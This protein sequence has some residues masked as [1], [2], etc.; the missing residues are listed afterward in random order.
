LNFGVRK[1]D[2]IRYRRQLCDVAWIAI[3]GRRRLGS[4]FLGAQYHTCDLG[5][6]GWPA[7][8]GRRRRVDIAGLNSTSAPPKWKV[9]VLAG[10][11]ITLVSAYRWALTLRGLSAGKYNSNGSLDTTGLSDLHRT[12]TFT[13]DQKHTA[14]VPWYVD[15]NS[16][17]DVT[18]TAQAFFNV[19]K[20]VLCGSPFFLSGPRG[21]AWQTIP[22][23]RSSTMM[24]LVR[25]STA[26]GVRF[27]YRRMPTYM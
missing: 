6:P 20:R 7:H 16:S 4:P 25:I 12:T 5:H 10:A 17:Y 14:P 23:R 8:P 21:N 22:S 27:Q 13:T 15:L 18:T 1:G 24:S 11:A 2:G 26:L 3:Q 19:E 9:S